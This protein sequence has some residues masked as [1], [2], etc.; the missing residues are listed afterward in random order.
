MSFR[1][2]NIYINSIFENEV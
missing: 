1:V 2:Q